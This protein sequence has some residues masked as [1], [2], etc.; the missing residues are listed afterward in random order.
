MASAEHLSDPDSSKDS[1][2]NERYRLDP[3]KFPKRLELELNE[4]LL[5]HLEE[6][7]AR[8]GRSLNDLIS[9]LLCQQL[10]AS[11]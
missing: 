4:S 7:A 6:R 3:A 1:K 2:P 10:D 5:H 9:E 11:T 8:S